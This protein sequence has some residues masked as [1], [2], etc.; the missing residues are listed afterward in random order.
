MDA[1]TRQAMSI[2]RECGHLD[3]RLLRQRLRMRPAGA[4]A[5]L[6]QLCKKGLITPSGRIRDEKPA[7]ADA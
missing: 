5:L 1:L 7:E 3:V 6:Q 4:Q 2:A